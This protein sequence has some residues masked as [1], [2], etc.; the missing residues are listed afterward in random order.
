MSIARLYLTALPL[1]L[2]WACSGGGG[3]TASPAAEWEKFRQ[4]TSNSGA[5]SG[6]ITPISITPQSVPV[7]APTPPAFATPSATPGA[8]SS[9]P[10]IAED[11]TVYIGS[12]GGTLAAFDANLNLKWRK[13]SCEAC[14][15]D[16][17]ATPDPAAA[18][19][20]STP[21]PLP[22]G[23]LISSPAVYTLNG[24]TSIFIGS[25][26]GSVFAFQDNGTGQPTCS[27]CFRPFAGTPSPGPT[28]VV[29]F[30][31][32]PSFTTDPV[33][34][35]VSGVF[36]GAQIELADGQ[37]IG[38]FYALNSDGSLKWQY[39]RGDESDIAPVTSSPALGS[40]NAWYF[41]TSDGYLYALTAEGSLPGSLIW[42]E[43]IGP[44]LGPT[45]GPTPP[46]APAVLATD[47]Y[48]LTPTGDGDVFAITPDQLLRFR[49]AAADSGVVSSLAFGASAAVT[50]SPTAVVVASPTSP[51]GPTATATA[52][53]TTGVPSFVYMVTQSGQIIG[54]RA[55]QP[56]PTVFPTAQTPITAP[57]LSSPALSSDGFLVFGDSD[58]QLHAVSTADGSELTGFP[59]RLT[60]RAIR[61]SPSIAADG[62]I[63]VGA[64]DGRLYAVGLP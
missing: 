10:A 19:P 63:Y 49:V 43:P 48:I 50:P 57:V 23:P 34:S 45:P 22:L 27:A 26:A 13:T 16:S 15:A 3:T 59:I 1:A 51:P 24:Q 37:S 40:S 46:F 44:A 33:V 29:K 62:T 21:T 64:D 18:I 8:I 17:Q 54:F 52:T 53:P 28:P 11:G 25:S 2:L 7:D 60:S 47:N 5:A 32:S 30:L 55:A 58:G 14:P 20:S 36:I 61:S 41:T 31:S 38:T 39:P 56:T 12:E 6:A 35:T 42:K 4:D 9:S